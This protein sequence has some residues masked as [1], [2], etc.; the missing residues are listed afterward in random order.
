MISSIGTAVRTTLEI[1]GPCLILVVLI[2][3][4][5]LWRVHRVPDRERRRRAVVRTRT[6]VRS[7]RGW[8]HWGTG[9]GIGIMCLAL[10]L[11]ILLLRLDVT[12]GTRIIFTA[13]VLGLPILFA[14]DAI[15]YWRVRAFH[16]RIERESFRIC[17][18]CYYSLAGHAEGGHCPECGYTFTPESLI[19]DWQDVY[20]AAFKRWPRT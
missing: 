14:A 15:S 17:P 11:G 18:D 16:R 8:E 19:E 1:A 20:K 7:A 10:G 6:L 3:G 12:A 5:L 13:S 4:P 9:A 2:A